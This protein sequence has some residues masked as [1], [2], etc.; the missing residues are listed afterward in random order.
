MVIFLS[1]SKIGFNKKGEN[2]RILNTTVYILLQI[3]ILDCQYNIDGFYS[4][5]K[6]LKS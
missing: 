3:I 5:K 2:L 1:F 4:I 6:L